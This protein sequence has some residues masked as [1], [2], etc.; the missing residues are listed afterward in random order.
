VLC[1]LVNEL[2][3]GWHRQELVVNHQRN[4]G[5]AQY[6]CICCSINGE[7]QEAVSA[8]WSA[9]IRDSSWWNHGL[10]IRYRWP[11]L[12]WRGEFR[13]L[14]SLIRSSHLIDAEHF[15]GAFVRRAP[16]AR[17]QSCVARHPWY[18]TNVTL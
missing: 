1:T 18:S 9:L 3:R 7:L 13:D 6:G 2:R 11:S 8:F 4:N 14:L 17:A 10:A 16:I 12:H 5:G 15:D